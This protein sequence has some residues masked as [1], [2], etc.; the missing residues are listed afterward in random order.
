MTELGA[1]RAP[2]PESVTAFK[3][4][5]K[6]TYGPLEELD[7]IQ[8]STVRGKNG[9]VADIK[10]LLPVSADSTTAKP[11]FAYGDARTQMKRTKLVN[12]GF[13]EALNEVVP[14]EGRRALTKIGKE[15]RR[16]LPTY[17]TVLNATIGGIGKL[18][19]AIRIFQDLFV[20]EDG[21]LYVRRLA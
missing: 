13:L 5:F 17:D 4:G 9:T 3:R 7:T 19:S 1:F 15:I 10:V 11:T 6:A 2:L 12:A 18:A 21:D 14:E 8:N 16:E 20:L